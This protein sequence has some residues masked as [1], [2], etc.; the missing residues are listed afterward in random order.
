MLF[1]P[2]SI[3]MDRDPLDEVRDHGAVCLEWEYLYARI[4]VLYICGC[5]NGEKGGEMQ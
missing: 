4:S 5:G 1:P 2:G 3:K